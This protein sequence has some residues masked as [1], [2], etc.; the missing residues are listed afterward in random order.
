MATLSIVIAV[1][2]LWVDL[3]VTSLCPLSFLRVMM[4]G[5]Q[6]I[7]T[8]GISRGTSFFRWQNYRSFLECECLLKFE[9]KDGF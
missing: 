8:D 3:F 7:R 2:C 6:L 9:E 4:Y 5:Q 1:G